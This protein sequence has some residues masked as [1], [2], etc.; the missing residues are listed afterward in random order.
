MKLN[1]IITKSFFTVSF[2]SA[3]VAVAA[4]A[5]TKKTTP[6]AS[7]AAA[8]TAKTAKEVTKLE[9]KD[10]KVGTGALAESGKTVSVNYR[11]RL[12]NGTEFDSSYSR[13]V[14]FEFP[15]GAGRVIKGWDEG[16]KGMKV[17]GK[18]TLTIPGDMAYGP[19]GAAGGKIPPNA[20]L[21]F[22]VELLNVL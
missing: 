5:S 10:V 19:Q 7:K 6:T 13:G 2:L 16:V 8:T 4:T 12:T 20:T 9:I 18:R 3:A 17:G 22:D 1:P 21:I 14:P 11:G 15:L